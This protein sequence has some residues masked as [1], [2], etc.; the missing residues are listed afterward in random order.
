[1]KAISPG[2][3]V[4]V[5]ILG[6]TTMP[7]RA[8]LPTLT[9][10]GEGQNAERLELRE[11]S[12]SVE[13]VGNVAE[14]VLEL[15]FFNHTSRQ[16]EGEFLLTLPS[17]ATVSSYALEVEGAMRPG[18]SVEKD[19]ARNA[20]ETIKRQRKDP[21]LVEKQ[22]GNVYR[23][24]IFPIA[25]NSPKR[26]RIGY[27]ESVPESGY[28]F[29][30]DHDKPLVLFRCQVSGGGKP[31][32]ALR[33][34]KM[35]AIHENGTLVWA[36]QD[37]S[38][39][40]ILEIGMALPESGELVRRIEREP[41][42]SSYVFAQGRM[43]SEWVGRDLSRPRKIRVIWDASDSGRGR[44]MD[45]E[46]GALKRYLEWVR[47]AEVEVLALRTRLE[48]VAHFRLKDGNA[49]PILKAVRGIAYDG[50]ADFSRIVDQ[51]G[52]TLLFTDGRLSSPA[53][54]L[55]GNLS[56]N[57]FFLVSS[58]S[59]PMTL[60][61][62]VRGGRVIDL[63]E[64]DWFDAMTRDL[65]GV[66]IEGAK[67]DAIRV[68]REENLFTITAKLSGAETKPLEV[69]APDGK[70]W[71]IDPRREGTEVAEWGFVRRLWA[72]RGLRELERSGTPEEI[73]AFAMAERL[74][75]DYTSVIVLERF[76]D[77]LRYRIPPPE[78]ELL[79]RYEREVDG[80]L[81]LGRQRLDRD[82]EDKLRWYR[83][84]YPWIDLKLANEVPQVAIWIKASR[85]TFPEDKLNR[86][87]LEPFEKWLPK[88]RQILK[89]KETLDGEADFKEWRESVG[90]SVERLRE[91]RE[92]NAARK[93]DD[94]IH[95][96]VRG[97]VNQRG[98]YTGESP[99]LLEEAV[100]RAGGPNPLWGDWGRVYLYRDAERTGYNLRST[101]YQS[102]PLRWGDMVV[103]ESGPNSYGAILRASGA[104]DFFAGPM[105]PFAAPAAG[106]E[107][108][109]GARRRNQ[110][111]AVFEKAGDFQPAVPTEAAGGSD[112][113]LDAHQR[114]D[115]E[116]YVIRF[117]ESEPEEL[118][119]GIDT[120]AV[121]AI[122]ES[123]NPAKVY[124]SWVRKR[125]ETPSVAT[126]VDMARTLCKKGEPELGKRALSNLL[127]WLPNSFE[128][129]RSYSLWLAEFGD[130][131]EAVAILSALAETI[132]D[133]VSQ[134][135]LRHDLAR[136][137]GDASDFRKSIKQLLRTDEPGPLGTLALTDYFG[138]GGRAEDEFRSLS[139]NPMPSDVR[140]VVVSSGDEVAIAVK[141]PE[142]EA[143]DWLGMSVHGGR[144][145]N[146]PRAH[147]YQMRYGLPGR[148]EL[149]C[150]RTRPG[151]EWR[152][153]VTL[154]VT[155]YSRW[156]KAG[157]ESR[158]AT[159]LMEGDE[160]NLGGLDFSWVK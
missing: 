29:S 87:A 5:A 90:R 102:V 72:Q 15:E 13:M 37:I 144:P 61:E 122:R 54:N 120:E 56:G 33:D 147:E 9:V 85:E 45:R 69:S 22:A 100:E 47:D 110:A 46:I 152:S 2:G 104:V 160:M 27:Q 129:A 67:G 58:V 31:R 99:F 28:R 74:V 126:A 105:D 75:S 7:L 150:R 98:I 68:E 137:S 96:S 43:P 35:E 79:E 42:G 131:E 153:P 48:S 142:A 91:I 136:F 134:A 64:D 26:V 21:G 76:V 109:P 111:P 133:P 62:R 30:F 19:R 78:P 51:S 151:G 93:S 63:R 127:E 156:A 92:I 124:E 49:A 125:T 154:R 108:G 138:A 107:T 119:T 18:V 14:T 130:Q 1:M 114:P 117:V 73:T 32:L 84:P 50:A 135:I 112:S 38:P 103:V 159:F 106:G 12:M 149:V 116:N 155:W 82:W 115:D 140:M 145:A 146:A 101:K 143:P 52:V 86:E 41:D 95:V 59:A 40:G 20:Y 36:A 81:T 44:D 94:G 123:Q 53:W 97:F 71:T 55:P 139:P 88:A 121:S 23:T 8:A 17:G 34:I 118:A 4:L 66:K 128:A 83:T 39:K 57:R 3:L 158:T 24:R 89:E 148:Y 25:A 70:S 65:M 141:E 6:L 157:E 60:E 132:A 11:L 10:V 16:Q 77:H 80:G 113:F